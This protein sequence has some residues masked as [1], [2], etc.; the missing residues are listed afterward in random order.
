M[1][2]IDDAALHFGGFLP[3]DGASTRAEESSGSKTVISRLPDCVFFAF[4][5]ASHADKA[6][7][8]EQETSKKRIIR[9]RI[10]D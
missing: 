8:V 2:S 3:S 4:T 7:N 10:A 9:L 1:M 5:R 6:A